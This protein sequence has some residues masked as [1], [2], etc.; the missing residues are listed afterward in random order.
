[1]PEFGGLRKRQSRPSMQIKC[2][3]LPNAEVGHNEKKKKR[4]VYP[5]LSTFSLPA[6]FSI[7]TVFRIASLNWK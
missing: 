3:A 4:T 6:L 7:L 5:L 2:Q 1:M